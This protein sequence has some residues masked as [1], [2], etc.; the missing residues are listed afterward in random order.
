MR[1]R[2]KGEKK[3]VGAQEEKVYEGCWLLRL[4]EGGKEGGG[5]VTCSPRRPVA[6]GSRTNAGPTARVNHPSNPKRGDSHKTCDIALAATW[7][8]SWLMVRGVEPLPRRSLRMDPVNDSA[9]PSVAQTAADASSAMFLW[10]VHTI[11]LV[12]I[13][14]QGVKRPRRVDPLGP[15]AIAGTG[16]KREGGEGGRQEVHIVRALPQRAK[17][18]QPRAH[19]KH[20]ASS[21]SPP[22]SGVLLHTFPPSKCIRRERASRRLVNASIWMSVG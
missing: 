7:P 11:D 1:E 10:I 12:C 8:L 15:R 18:S 20:I 21:P 13:G 14:T 2:E 19:A 9:S 4:R 22:A 3:G 5:K 6:P 16:A 17:P